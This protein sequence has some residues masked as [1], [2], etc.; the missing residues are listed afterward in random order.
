MRKLILQMMVSLDGFFEG[1]K[2]ELDWH[3]WDEEMEKEAHE[4]L[5]S[6]DA[7]LL[8]RVAYQLFAD[9]WPKAKDSIAPKLNRLPKIVFSKTLE[10]TE[11]NNSGLFKGDIR[12][13]FS[14]AKAAPGKDFILYG[15]GSIASTFMRL[16]LID[17]YR[18]IVNPVVLGSGRPLFN[19]NARMNLELFKTRN[20]KCGNVM[21]YYQPIRKGAL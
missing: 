18:L 20:F 19:G 15:G 12:K 1:P 5:D 8:G 9:Y 3:V 10:K 4:T 21:L 7:I 17:E 2:Q 16:G 13:E 14:E 6:V 11:W